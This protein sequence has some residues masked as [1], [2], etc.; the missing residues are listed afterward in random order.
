MEKLPVPGP[1]AHFLG[2]P[3][4]HGLQDSEQEGLRRFWLEGLFGSIALAL[5][6]S[7]YTLYALSLGVTASQIGLVGTLSQISSAGLAI[8]GAML[9]ERSGRYKF[10][11]QVAQFFKQAMWLVMALAPWLL[12][13]GAAIVVV[14]AAWIGI[15]I[16]ATVANGAWSALSGEIVPNRIRGQYFASRNILMN[17]S[18]IL[19]V[20]TAGFFVKSIGEPLGYQ[21]SLSLAF[22]I[23]LLAVY[24]FSRLPEHQVSAV[25]REPFGLRDML[26]GLRAYPTFTRFMLSHA[27]VSFGVQVGGPFIQVYMV[28]GAGFDV[29]TISIINTM[30]VFAAMLSMYVFGRWQDRKGTVWIMRFAV[31]MPLIPVLWLWVQEPWHGWVAQFYA[32]WAWTGYNLGAFNLLLNTTPQDH[33]PRYLALHM[34]IS[35]LVGSLGPVIGGWLLDATGFLLIFALS[36]IIRSVGMILFL[37]LVREPAPAP[38]PAPVPVAVSAAETPPESD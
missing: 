37:A 11:A 32:S 23:G 12:P 18:K 2:Y 31:A 24:H 36:T 25:E 4:V 26:R 20:P 1:V 27:V 8:P 15:S 28:Q 17:F 30:G 33:R 9:A 38:V 13:T 22:L 6:E 35:A 16:F 21:F 34:T 7:F 10:T 3:R 29:A 5:S 19:L 14:L